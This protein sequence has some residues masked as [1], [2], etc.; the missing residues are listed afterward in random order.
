MRVGV[1]D[2]GSNSTRLLIADVNEQKVSPVE[3][4]LVT[5]RMGRGIKKRTIT[6][7]AM[8]STISVMKEFCNRAALCGIYKMSAF[9]TSAVRD[10]RNSN[11]FVNQVKQELGIQVDVLSGE[12]EAYLNYKGVISGLNKSFLKEVLIDL[13]GG[14]IEFV[15]PG[16]GKICWKSVNAG[17][18]R[19]TEG[20][21]NDQEIK[22]LLR[23]VLEDISKVGVNELIGMGGTI[24]NL[25]AISLELKTYDPNLVHG[26]ILT[27]NSIQKT[28]KILE[29]TPVDKRKEIP[30]LQPERAD[31]IV[32]GTRIVKIVMDCLEF[33][34]IEV[35][36][37]DILYGLAVELAQNV[38]RNMS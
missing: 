33:N 5:T 38:E 36:E 26:Y 8:E 2:I 35:S 31:I 20:K 1:I 30:G 27:Y 37:A 7:E 34:C 15:W 21:H 17:A 22:S 12:E 13:G 6:K 14:S 32:A 10:A 3:T 24:T 4:D 28:L 18:V 19:M 29:N 9:A 25:A 11:E 23:P 16:T